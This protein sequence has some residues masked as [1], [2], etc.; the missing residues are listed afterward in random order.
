MPNPIKLV[1]L[2]PTLCSLYG[3][4]ANVAVLERHLR[5]LGLEVTVEKVETVAQADL[6]NAAFVFMGAATEKSQKAA[7]ADLMT[8]RDEI[9]SLAEAG[10]PMLFTG[11]SFELLGR[12][13]IDADGRVYEALGLCAFHSV[14][15]E[16]R[17]VGD[18]YG[19][20]SLYDAPVVGFMN[21]CSR[22]VGV[23]T[24]LLSAL[25]LGFG[26]S[27][28]LGGEG[29]V[30]GSVVGTHL[31]GPVLVKNPLLLRHFAAAICRRA[32]AA[33]P[34]TWPAYP[35]EEQGYAITARELRKRFEKA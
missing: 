18:V 33:V 29:V 10:V 9:V 19:A 12:Q 32:G 25:S 28:D 22:T 15:G 31:T 1:H 30:A 2:Y 11:C 16:K 13:V 6:Q 24:P 5:D 21:K 8:R 3:D 14:E 17:I 7:L 26:N 23:E 35:Y 4:W 20:S 34:E 27:E